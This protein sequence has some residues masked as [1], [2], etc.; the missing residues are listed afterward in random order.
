MY[1][2]LCLSC[3]PYPFFLFPFW[4]LYG[5]VIRYLS[6]LKC[7]T[8]LTRDNSGWWT[9]WRVEAQLGCHRNPFLVDIDLFWSTMA[10]Q[11][12][13]NI[14]IPSFLDSRCGW[15]FELD[16]FSNRH[17]TGLLE[18]WHACNAVWCSCMLIAKNHH[19]VLRLFSLDLGMSESVRHIMSSCTGK[20]AHSS[21]SAAT[22]SSFVHRHTLLHFHHCYGCYS[23]TGDLSCG[24]DFR[25]SFNISFLIAWVQNE[26]HVPLTYAKAQLFQ[27]FQCG[28]H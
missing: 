26:G 1:N 8:A 28:A 12:P 11:N 23:V 4:S 7:H 2:M 19:G 15:V 3:L 5:K 24:Q 25:G 16:N 14:N 21:S 20:M 10:L 22:L 9:W 17:G 6:K 27:T 18:W 13:I